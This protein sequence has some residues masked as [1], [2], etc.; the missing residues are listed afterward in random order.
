MRKFNFAAYHPAIALI[1]GVYWLAGWI[2]A[3]T[4]W[5]IWSLLKLLWI[6]LVIMPYRGIVAGRNAIHERRIARAETRMRDYVDGR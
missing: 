6:G 3:L 1:I 5:L 4:V 2:I